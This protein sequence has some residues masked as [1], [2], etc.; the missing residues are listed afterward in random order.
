MGNKIVTT[1]AITILLAEDEALIALATQDALEG[2][3]FAVLRANDGG[4]A[5][6]L[7]ESRSGDIQGL[8]TDVR[9]GTGPSGWEVARHARGLNS[10]LPIVYITGDSG[11]DWPVE[12]VPCSVVLPKPFAEAQL[13]T[14]LAG[15]L[16]AGAQHCRD[17]ANGADAS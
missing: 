5:L 7:L 14:A 13:I 8:V 6:S 16:N 2:A 17:A 11:A 1:P 10:G 4:E 12:G 15:L 3:G 9:L